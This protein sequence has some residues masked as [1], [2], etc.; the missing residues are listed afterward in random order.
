MAN[1][2]TSAQCLLRL[3]GCCFALALTNLF[4]LPASGMLVS[5]SGSF[6]DDGSMNDLDADDHEDS[7]EPA[8]S[9][10]RR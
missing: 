1:R 8:T 3:L 9:A 4:S 10:I 5:Y 7:E 2:S 6:E